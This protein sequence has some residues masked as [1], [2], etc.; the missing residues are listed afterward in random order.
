MFATE[1][2]YRN[3]VHYL[4]WKLRLNEYFLQLSKVLKKIYAFYLIYK[5]GICW[6]QIILFKT[7][8]KKK[9]KNTSLHYYICAVRRV[10]LLYEYVIDIFY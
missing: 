10:F 5:K 7:S 9:K 1:T 4:N 3:I 6:I 8:Q 2:S